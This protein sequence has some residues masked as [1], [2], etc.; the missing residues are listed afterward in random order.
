MLQAT[1]TPAVRF[2]EKVGVAPGT[3]TINIPGPGGGPPNILGKHYDPYATG[4][5]LGN[6]YDPYATP[7]TMKG[8]NSGLG[9]IHEGDAWM[10]GR[11]YGL[12]GTATVRLTQGA[13][14]KYS[15]TL[16]GPD[17]CTATPSDDDATAALWML[18]GS[19]RAAQKSLHRIAFWTSLLGGLTVGTVAAAIVAG[20]ASR[21]EGY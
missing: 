15:A 13:N 19:Q 9:L 3:M 7:T 20:V 14:G 21:R 1:R 17:G 5:N 12:P 18:A 8:H 4:S 2:A 11:P 10:T 16:R 6:Q